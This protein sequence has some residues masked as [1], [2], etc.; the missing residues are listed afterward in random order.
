[1]PRVNVVDAGADPSGNEPIDPILD[2]HNEAETEFYFP[3]GRYRLNKFATDRDCIQFRGDNATIVPTERTSTEK[4]FEIY[5]TGFVL[6]GFELDMRECSYTP[7]L[8]IKG[9]EWTIQN[10]VV[11]GR[12][13]TNGKDM[14]VHGVSFLKP[15]VTDPDGKGVLRNVYLADGSGPAGKRSAGRAV[16][17]EGA[18]QKGH[19]V[20]EQCW[21]EQWGENTLYANNHP[22]EIT[23]RNCTFRNTN[24]GVRLGGNSTVEGTTFVRDYTVEMPKQSWSGGCMMRGIRV[25][26]DDEWAYPGE[27]VVRDCDFVFYRPGGWQES[28]SPWAT[29]PPLTWKA[30]V[31][32]VTIEDCRIRYDGYH[33][34]AIDKN[35]ALGAGDQPQKNLTI[36]NVQV[37]HRGYED[38]GVIRLKRKPKTIDEISG[39]YK[40]PGR[41]IT[42]SSV[43]ADLSAGKPTQATPD[44]PIPSPPSVGQA[45]SGNRVP[46]DADLLVVD[47]RKSGKT[48]Y[49]FEVSG[50]IKQAAEYGASIDRDDT[51]SDDGKRVSGTAN[52]GIDAYRFTGDLRSAEVSGQPT[53]LFAAA[54][55][56]TPT[57]TTVDELLS[58]EV[59]SKKDDGTS[60]K[61]GNRSK[62]DGNTS[63]KNDDTSKKDGDTPKNSG[64]ASKKG[65]GGFLKSLYV[66]LYRFFS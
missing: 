61:D 38:N 33:G 20:F 31:E 2:E 43:T 14:N 62:K 49:T 17:V 47:A 27:L 55:E 6:D 11:R 16:L 26:G 44:A 29:R 39:V 57:K 53:L 22:G 40:S 51:V 58:F 5:S 12:F 54:S 10:L 59:P 56:T 50:T 52:G 64:D 66:E 15:Y 23:I 28:D 7:G 13:R 1:M 32:S 18:D 37:D 21:F 35:D 24:V 34:Y 3:E 45:P 19:V 65:V 4:L 42:P 25:E 36:S 60:K 9:D 41:G 46:E 48:D 63:K 30:P 8:R